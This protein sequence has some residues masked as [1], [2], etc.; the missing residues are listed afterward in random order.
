MPSLFFLELLL[1]LAYMFY[2]IYTYTHT[3]THLSLYTPFTESQYLKAMPF[4]QV[5]KTPLAIAVVQVGFLS[6]IA[7]DLQTI[8]P[9]F[10]QAAH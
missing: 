7:Q 2:F 9:V 4:K 3:H 5:F 1:L 6:Y 8:F 10:S